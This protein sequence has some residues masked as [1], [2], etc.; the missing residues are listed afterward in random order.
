MNYCH[1]YFTGFIAIALSFSL[2]GCGVPEPTLISPGVYSIYKRDTAGVFGNPNKMRSDV[3]SKANSF[4]A[5]RGMV[6]APAGSSFTPMGSGPGQ[7]A[8]FDYKFYLLTPSEYA[9]MRRKSKRDWESLT[10]AQRLAYEQREAELSQGAQALALSQESINQA[11]SA[12]Y[13]DAFLRQQQI[14]AYQQR[15]QTLNQPVDVNV[16]GT[17][18]HNVNRPGIPLL[19]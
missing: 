9:E 16:R 15:T 19:Y 6:A 12:Q 11:A 14:N 3:V 8:S 2:C 5:T 4:A 17:I 10:P 18:N 7:F 1:S 13:Q